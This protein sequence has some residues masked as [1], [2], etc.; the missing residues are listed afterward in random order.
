[1]LASLSLQWAGGHQPG[2]TLVDLGALTVIIN[3]K[4]RNPEQESKFN[5][6]EVRASFSRGRSGHLAPQPW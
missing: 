1:M 2:S 6:L 4:F 3:V 5:C